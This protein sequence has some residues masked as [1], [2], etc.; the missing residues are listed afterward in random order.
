MSS[1]ATYAQSMRRENTDRLNNNNGSDVASR[2]ADQ[3]Q[4]QNNATAIE[5]RGQMV[6]ISLEHEFAPN[7]Q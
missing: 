6:R 1:L 4:N 3:T 2:Q 5:N 7:S